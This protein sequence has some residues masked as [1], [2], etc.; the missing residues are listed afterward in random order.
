MTVRISCLYMAVA[1]SLTSSTSAQEWKSGVDW[2]QP[3]IVAPGATN[4]Q[5]PSDAIVL[6]GG[7]D[8]SA[9]ENGDQWQIQDGIA[10]PRQTKIVS[11]QHFGDIQLH[12]EW[13][14]PTE[15]TGDGQARGNSGVY[16]MGKYEVQILDSHEN[17][18]YFDGQAGAV[19]KQTPP[20]ANAMRKPGEWNTYDIF[21][22][23]PA[24]KVNGDV[25]KPGFVT[26]IHNGVLALNHFELL[27]PS[28][29]VA[30]P[31]Y[32]PHA[33]TGPISLQFHGDPVRFRNIWL[34]EL[35]PAVGKRTSAGFN[36]VKEPTKEPGD[37][38]ADKAGQ[39]KSDE[40]T[41]PAKDDK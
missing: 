38:G 1:L 18:T 40:P 10:I 24:F 33:E 25:E 32:E 9:F 26:L 2:Q 29:Y 15:I 37:K 12:L 7:R 27:G 3:P 36:I 4:D 20:L 5:P 31:H 19:Y 41:D 13:S 23:A 28:S 22:T 21:F 35:K 17:E 39:K 30:A 14:A 16:L 8:L 34:R 6:F 11:K